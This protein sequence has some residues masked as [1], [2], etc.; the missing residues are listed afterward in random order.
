MNNTL[1]DSSCWLTVSRLCWNMFLLSLF[2][3]GWLRSRYGHSNS[4]TCEAVLLA[5][6]LQNIIHSAGYPGFA[7]TTC[8]PSWIWYHLWMPVVTSTSSTTGLENVGYPCAPALIDLK[9]VGNMNLEPRL[10]RQ[11]SNWTVTVASQ[12]WASSEC[13]QKGG[14][15]GLNGKKGQGMPGE[16]DDKGTR[17]LNHSQNKWHWIITLNVF[18]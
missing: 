12:S 13:G 5:A 11:S 6:Q 15:R 17:G 16:K 14:G 7:S 4:L 9:G 10:A 18:G 2:G 1:S 3:Q 8:R